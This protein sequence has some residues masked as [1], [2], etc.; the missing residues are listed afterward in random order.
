MSRYSWL[1]FVCTAL[2][3]IDQLCA[4]H[5][6]WCAVPALKKYIEYIHHAGA[7]IAQL[8]YQLIKFSCLK[9]GNS[10]GVL[11]LHILIR[12]VKAC[13]ETD[14]CVATTPAAL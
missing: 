2:Q 14:R 5:P 12:E 6:R 8:H 9:E 13:S 1:F 3:R 11:P 4:A 10:T 7:W